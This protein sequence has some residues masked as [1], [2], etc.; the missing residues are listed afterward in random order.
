[1]ET[2]FTPGPWS[3][4]ESEHEVHSDV[5]QDNGGDPYHICEMLSTKRADVYLVAAAPEMYYALVK[6][7][8]LVGRISGKHTTESFEIAEI[9][10][11]VLKK[12]RGE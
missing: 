7:R 6:I 9:I 4:D 10:A 12:A 5:M 8:K 3:Y 1:M 2:K 11:K